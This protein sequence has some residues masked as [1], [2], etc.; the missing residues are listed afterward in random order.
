MRILVCDDYESGFKA[1][2]CAIGERHLVRRLVGKEL[3]SELVG[4]FK[5]VSASLSSEAASPSETETPAEMFKGVDVAIVDNN[6]SALEI[7]GARL[8]AESIVGYI[9]AFTN[10][11]YVVSLNKNPDVDFDLRY[12]AGDY[13]SHAD[14]ALNASHL[15]SEVLWTGHGATVGSGEFAPWYWPNLGVAAA[16][17]RCQV[18]GLEQ[19][20]VEV[21]LLDFL[22]F[23]D[24]CVDALSRRARGVLSSEVVGAAELRQ[25]SLRG[26]FENACRA[27]PMADRKAVSRRA[28]DGDPAAKTWIARLAAADLEKWMRRDVLSPQ[29]V[30]V[31]LPHLLMRMPFLLGDGAREGRRWNRALSAMNPP[32]G[33]VKEIYQEHLAGSM[34]ERCRKW[35]QAP[36]FWWPE[37]RGSQELSDLF[38]RSKG[39][40]ADV[41]FCEDV[42][43]FRPI[44]EAADSDD[45]KSPPVEFEAEFE[46]AWRRRYVAAMEGKQYSPR[47][48]F[49]L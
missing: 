8:T 48:R 23:P 25:V 32:F 24:H 12:L 26:F 34:F 16:G 10:V 4:L 5:G 9:R 1:V 3:R 15:R 17:R 49:A 41:V 40:W 35:F 37:L 14:V 11:A 31:D 43:E 22:K 33:L 42:S 7:A 47:S 38:F 45:G 19:G 44:S 28:K 29:D 46:G 13:Q 30:L 36:C 27:L 6:L 21:P 20:G 2:E 18:A 39:E